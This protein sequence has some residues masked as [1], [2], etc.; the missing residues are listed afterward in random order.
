MVAI[1]V[2]KTQVIDQ[3]RAIDSVMASTSEKSS[4]GLAM[5]QPPPPT[6][7]TSTS[8]STP[9]PPLTVIYASATGTAE[10]LA[11]RIRRL[12]LRHHFPV[13]VLPFDKRFTPDALAQLPGPAI[14]LVATA[15]NGSFPTSAEPPWQA[16]LSTQLLAGCTLTALQFAI[17]G[18][19]DTSYPRF[20]WP[21]RMLRKRLVDLGAREIAEKGEGDEQ[22]YL[23]IEGTFQPFCKT[24]F[25]ALVEEYPTE[26][27]VLADDVPLPPAVELRFLDEGGDSDAGGEVD[28]AN[29]KVNG[30]GQ[31][32][33]NGDGHRADPSTL[34]PP[35]PTAGP[36]TPSRP[37]STSA[38]PPRWLRLT[39][40]E[41]LTSPTHW[42]DVR[43]IELQV[44]DAQPDLQYEAGDVAALRPCNDPD[45]V[46]ALIKRMGWEKDR[47]RPVGLF[48]RS[49]E[50]VVLPATSSANSPG[51]AMT[52]FEY[53]RDHT[54]P[55]SALRPSLFPLLRPFT[56]R[57]HIEHEKL[58]EF[59]TPGD[60]YE[61]AMDYGVRTR[62]TIAEVLEEFKSVQFPPKYAP[63][64]FGSGSSSGMREREFS[65]AS[66]P[67]H[68]P[69]TL[70]LIV[71]IVE[72]KT[73][74]KEPRRGVATRWL[75]ALDPK[76]DDDVMIPVTLR[77]SPLLRLPPS[78]S[79]PIIAVGP[80]TGM[81]PIRGLVLERLQRPAPAPILVFLGCRGYPHDDALLHEEWAQL[82]QAHPHTL[83]VHWASSRVDAATGA[84]RA[85]GEKEY[86]QDLITRN[87]TAVCDLIQDGGWVYISGSSGS[88]PTQVRRAVEDVCMEEMALER[89]QAQRFVDRL[90][91]TGRWREECWS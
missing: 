71:A 17:F 54:S 29:G 40:N 55:F 50:R 43:L 25:E 32:F 47:D 70:T 52:L 86:V 60:G 6:S 65:I 5:T 58:T 4:K 57:D 38:T 79:T 35:S 11:Q 44:P 16:L 28:A 78:D 83:S 10:D 24:L 20:C 45:A 21:E 82:A 81:A 61:D 53:L 23:G 7:S 12:A 9:R 33:T 80:G 41:R 49:G 31:M 77:S 74:I 88:M 8:T 48:N 91:A 39:R 84:A 26:E 42:Q 69:R 51:H 90:E 76:D 62:R 13:D 67:T 34:S 75:A 27:A 14:F 37:P 56:P 22:H 18:L 36:S 46:D 89:D 63:E 66:S 85:K 2:N 19:G 1:T 3:E 64:V 72:Y 68:T 73:R 59:S 15:G 30:T 87:A